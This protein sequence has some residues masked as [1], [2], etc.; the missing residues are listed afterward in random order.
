MTVF[1]SAI[2]ITAIIF[3]LFVEQGTMRTAVQFII[4]VL[5]VGALIVIYLLDRTKNKEM[6]VIDRFGLTLNGRIMLGPIPWDCILDAEINR[7][8]RYI[9]LK[10]KIT[11]ISKM[12][13]IFGAEAIRKN[14]SKSKNTDEWF[15]FMDL[16]DCNIRGIKLVTL[17]KERANGR[18]D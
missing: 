8:M 17:I 12:E 10:V 11:N 2:L 3:A 6:I 7:I 1:T 18:A 16:S 4:I 14:V 5:S 15:I 13:G 9:Q